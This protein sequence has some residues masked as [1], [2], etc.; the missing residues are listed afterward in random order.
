MLLQKANKSSTFCQRDKMRCIGCAEVRSAYVECANAND[1]PPIVGTSYNLISHHQQLTNL[2]KQF[3]MTTQTPYDAMGGEQAILNLVDRF[4]FYMDTLPEAAGIRAIHQADLS[5]AKDKLFKFL[6]GWLGGPNLFI[7][8]FGHPLTSKATTLEEQANTIESSK[9]EAR[10]EISDIFNKYKKSLKITTGQPEVID[11]NGHTVMVSMEVFVKLTDP[12]LSLQMARAMNKYFTS[13]T[14]YTSYLEA[15]IAAGGNKEAWDELVKNDLQAK[16]SFL[17]D[18]QSISLF[19]NFDYWFSVKITE[20]EVFKITFSV[21][22][23]NLKL[24]P[25][26]TIRLAIKNCVRKNGE[27]MCVEVTH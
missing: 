24:N 25:T 15:S 26:P 16:I 13:V 14:R 22:K 18:I 8:E 1:A 11:S 21:D 3:A 2:T 6:S 20:E 12:N 7:E 23:K 17:G 9:N 19:G 10:K 4:Y 27:N 5:S